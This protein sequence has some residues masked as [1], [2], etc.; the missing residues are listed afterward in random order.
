MYIYEMRSVGFTCSFTR[1]PFPFV[2]CSHRLGVC[3]VA[4]RFYARLEKTCRVMCGRLDSAQG[5]QIRLQAQAEDNGVVDIR[6]SIGIMDILQ[7][8]LD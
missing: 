4:G 6:P 8:G 3:T 2:Y 7:V 1:H 5:H